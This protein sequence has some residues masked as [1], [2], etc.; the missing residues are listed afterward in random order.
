MHLSDPQT[1]T[2]E[3][4]ATP[5]RTFRAVGQVCLLAGLIQ[6]PTSLATKLAAVP[7]S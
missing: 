4:I 6:E 7:A 2:E 1:A 5:I 3:A